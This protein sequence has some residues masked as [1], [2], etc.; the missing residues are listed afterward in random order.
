M[1]AAALTGL[2]GGC[3]KARCKSLILRPAP[4]GGALRLYMYMWGPGPAP[5]TVHALERIQAPP[6]PVLHKY[7]VHAQVLA[8]WNAPR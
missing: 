2:R 4:A 1:S 8:P 6:S 5:I 7:G 3:H